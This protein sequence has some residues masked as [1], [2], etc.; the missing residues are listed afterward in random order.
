MFQNG[1][2]FACMR[3]KRK[4]TLKENITPIFLHRCGFSYIS[5]INEIFLFQ[6]MCKGKPVGGRKLNRTY[7]L[8]WLSA[9]RYRIQLTSENGRAA[10]H[11]QTYAIQSWLGKGNLINII[12]NEIEREERK[13]RQFSPAGCRRRA[14]SVETATRKR[15]ILV[16]K[17][18][19]VRGHAGEMMK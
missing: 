18:R 13:K 9:A 1:P 3:V 7:S 8:H 12:K 17:P 19:K 5:N 10:N 16:V 14:I 2:S 4:N 6:D 15:I 11:R